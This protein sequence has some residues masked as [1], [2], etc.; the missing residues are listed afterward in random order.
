MADSTRLP[1][2]HKHAPHCAR[3]KKDLP[4]YDDLVMMLPAQTDGEPTI[5]RIEIR[6]HVVCTC[7]ARWVLVKES[8][9]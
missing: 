8:Q 3:C 2:Q 1:V 4:T 5:D 7:G 6:V 9:P